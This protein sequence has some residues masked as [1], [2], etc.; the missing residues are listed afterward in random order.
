MSENIR[1]SH[2]A[3]RLLILSYGIYSNCKTQ[4]RIFK[5]NINILFI[6]VGQYLD[7]FLFIVYLLFFLEEIFTFSNPKM[8]QKVSCI[9]S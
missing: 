6:E 4:C 2:M 5:P 1:D 7:F 3:V 8:L 9:V